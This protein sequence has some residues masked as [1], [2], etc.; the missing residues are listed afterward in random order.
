M[1]MTQQ[2]INGSD[3]AVAHLQSLVC[4]PRLPVIS[5]SVWACPPC[6]NAS[7]V[8][9]RSTDQH[10]WVWYQPQQESR[11]Q[12]HLGTV[13]S[14]CAC[15]TNDTSWSHCSL[16]F[17]RQKCIVPVAAPDGL[18]LSCSHILAALHSS[19][20]QSP[21]ATG[22]NSEAKLQHHGQLLASH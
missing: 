21:N 13:A 11:A 16:L 15:S 8:K 14:R 19:Q 6:P 10:G 3:R 1:A 18:P 5:Q 17:E 2:D 22:L 7:Q 12:H 4:Q 9:P 20:V